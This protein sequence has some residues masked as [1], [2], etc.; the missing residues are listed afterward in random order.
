MSVFHSTTFLYISL[1]CHCLLREDVNKMFGSIYAAI[2]QKKTPII[3]FHSLWMGGL[4][5]SVNVSVC[6]MV[7]QASSMCVCVM[8]RMHDS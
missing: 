4:C 3:L 5:K 1:L 8:Q 7:L 2:F 6:E